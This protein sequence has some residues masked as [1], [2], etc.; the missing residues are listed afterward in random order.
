MAA[1]NISLTSSI[2]SCRIDS[3][4]ANKLASDRF[5]NPEQVVAPTWQGYDSAGRSACFDSFNTKTAGGNSP[6]DRV[7]VENYLRPNYAEQ[8]TL[9]A[10]GIS[11]AVYGAPQQN[12]KDAQRVLKEAHTRTGTFDNDFNATIRPNCPYREA[13]FASNANLNRHWQADAIS[14][15]A[16]QYM[17]LAGAYSV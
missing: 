8:V 17:T 5:L 1:G 4:W 16:K 10:G 11:G 7:L 12:V 2:R 14:T 9:S 6:L 13:T 15:Q 3:G